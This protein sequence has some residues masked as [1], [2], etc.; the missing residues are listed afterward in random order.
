VTEV[1]PGD[2]RPKTPALLDRQAKAGGWRSGPKSQNLERQ[3]EALER[4]LRTPQPAIDY[5]Q[6]LLW[7]RFQLYAQNEEDGIVFALVMLERP[8]VGSFVDIG[9]G[10]NGGNSGMLARELLFGGLMLDADPDLT[11][12][13]ARLFARRDVHVREAFVLA[14]SIDEQI[15]AAGLS[16]DIDFLSIDIDGNDI[17]IWQAITVVSP[18][19]VCVEYNGLFGAEHA[20]AVPYESAFR[21]SSDT[22]P[23]RLRRR[24]YGASLKALC[25]IAAERGY[26]LVAVEPRGTNAFFLRHD[27]GEEVP[28]VD[29]K[30]AFWMLDKNQQRALRRGDLIE[31]VLAANL[32]LTT[33]P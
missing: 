11:R 26:R 13:C 24:Y 5:P 18:R 10:H 7:N 3:L 8:W 31:A 6:R 22:I 25:T 12:E 27:I 23:A 14:E 28:G 2:A 16:G 4:L 9:C 32:P 33:F 21:R 30:D 20:C 17:W 1:R 19:V 15:E 29:P